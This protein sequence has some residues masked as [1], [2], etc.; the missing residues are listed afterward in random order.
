MKIKM[1]VA[2]NKLSKMQQYEFSSQLQLMTLRHIGYR[3]EN[4]SNNEY[5]TGS[6]IINYEIN[7]LNNLDIFDTILDIYDVQLKTVSD[8]NK[9]IEQKLG[10]DYQCL[11][12]CSNPL[13]TVYLYS[14]GHKQYKSIHD[15]PNNIKIDK[16]HIPSTA[17]LLSDIGVD[18]QLFAVPNNYQWHSEQ[19]TI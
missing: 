17:I 14:D 15:I 5:H 11:W 4:Q 1:I 18:G 19:L 12:L 8:I 6:E 9:A 3:T 10:K 7:E 13:D 16:Y 2:I